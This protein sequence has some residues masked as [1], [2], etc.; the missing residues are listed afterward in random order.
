MSIIFLGDS[1]SIVFDTIYPNVITQWMGMH[2]KTTM[3]HF[4]HDEIYTIPSNAKVVIFSYG[5]IDTRYSI[6][7]QIIKPTNNR[8]ME[9]IIDDLC[10]DYVHKVI[11]YRDMYNIKVGVYNI[12]PTSCKNTESIF[13]TLENRKLVSEKM[14]L[15]L[16][17]CC[18]QLNVPFLKTVDLLQDIN[19]YLNVHL[20][21]KNGDGVHLDRKH[22][23]VLLPRLVEFTETSYCIARLD[24]ESL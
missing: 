16:E 22:Q 7:K 6:H 19:G 24:T 20:A 10:N 17:E 15:K 9:Q 23:S 13:S 8:T 2:K 21:D 11:K 5:E 3:H 18:K 1:H 4:N 14:N 12:P